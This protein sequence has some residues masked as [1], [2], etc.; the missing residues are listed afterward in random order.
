MPSTAIAHNNKNIPLT[1]EELEFLISTS[2]NALMQSPP[3]MATETADSIQICYCNVTKSTEKERIIKSIWEKMQQLYMNGTIQ[4]G[5]KVV[6]SQAIDKRTH[7]Y[8]FS[9]E[10]VTH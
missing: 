8:L 6:Q 4:E 1:K 7:S 3:A 9:I 2:A 10:Q 5:T